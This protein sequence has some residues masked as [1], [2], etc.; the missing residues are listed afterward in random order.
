MLIQTDVIY[1]IAKKLLNQE[2]LCQG[3]LDVIALA[4][5]HPYWYPV[6]G[7]MDFDDIL[8][9]EYN[10]DNESSED[11]GYLE[12]MRKLA[13]FM[14]DSSISK[15]VRFKPKSLLIDLGALQK[16][17]YNEGNIGA[18]TSALN[19]LLSCCI[20]I[21][22]VTLLFGA[23]AEDN[24]S[25]Y[26]AATFQDISIRLP[27]LDLLTLRYKTTAK[28]SLFKEAQDYIENVM[29]PEI[30]L[31][32]SFGPDIHLFTAIDRNPNIHNLTIRNSDI[33]ALLHLGMLWHKL[34]KINVDA[35]EPAALLWV[36]FIVMVGSTPSELTELS[37]QELTDNDLPCVESGFKNLQFMPR[38]H[39]NLSVL[40]IH[41]I[42]FLGDEFLWSAWNHLSKLE[43]LQIS[44]S[45]ALTGDISMLDKTKGWK[46]LK[47]LNLASCHH[48]QGSFPLLAID[49]TQSLNF[50]LTLPSHV[51]IDEELLVR[52]FE[53][54]GSSSTGQLWL[55]RETL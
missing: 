13:A 39:P 4:Q 45:E 30:E 35:L 3:I 52:G 26:L 48:L 12:Y 42:H 46:S 32:G 47:T 24:D 37:Y 55:R 54:H 23:S 2:N 22:H 15:H 16:S 7:I 41:N 53:F 49:M 5:A 38:L 25:R 51:N 27:Q 36:P 9:N 21:N 19:Q 33:S 29:V 18:F 6:L 28:F 11:L 50:Q 8:D 14:A 43:H 10:F 31:D 44:F 17:Q 40:K 20:N 34:K 1:S